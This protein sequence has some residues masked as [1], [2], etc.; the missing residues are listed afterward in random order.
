MKPFWALYRKEFQQYLYSLLSYIFIVVFLVT[1]SWLFWRNV[2]LVGQTN[3]RDFFV[4]M[5][6][7]YLFLMPAL[8]M[9]LWSEEKRS[10]TTEKLFTFPLSDTQAVLA[11]FTAAATFLA[12]VLGLSLP[13]PYT[14]SKIGSLDWGPVIGSYIGAWLLGSAYLALGQWISGLTK[15]Q[16]VAFLITIIAAFG[17]LIIGLPVIQGANSLIGT[18]FYTL[19]TQTHFTNL[20]KGVI[21]LRDVVYYVSFI[22]VF[23][24]LNIQTLLKRQQTIHRTAQ[25]VLV[26]AI[27][28]V[29]NILLSSAVWRVDLTASK[30]FT[31][32]QAS[33]NI[34]TQ[35]TDP[36]TIKVMFS[37]ELP[38]NLLALRQDVHDLVGEYKRMGKGN[39]T[40]EFVDPKSDT[41]VTTQAQT[42]GVPEIQFNVVGNESF[43]V[44]T[45]YAGIVMLYHDQ[46]Q[47]IP[48]IQDTANLEYDITS[49]LYKM[50]RPD[51]PSIGLLTGYGEV[52][53]GNLQ[54][55]LE[56]Q[57]TVESLTIDNLATTPVKTLMI[58]GPT[59]E[60][61]DKDF[62]AIDQFIMRG[63]NVFVAIDGSIINPQLLQPTPNIT[64]LNQLLS[65][66]GITVNADLIA[67]FGAAATLPFGSGGYQ[68][69]RE[70]PYWPQVSSSGFNPESPVTQ[71]LQGMIL[72]WPS[73]LTTATKDT[74]HVTELVRTTDQSQAIANAT[75]IDPE[76]L[77][78]P[79]PDALHSQ[80]VAAMSS[81]A[82]PSYYATKDK[83][84]DI[85]SSA[86]SA[87][88]TN[89]K[90]VVIS[91]AQFISDDMLQQTS[92]NALI[93]LNAVDVLS[94]DESLVSIRSR[95]AL[96]RPLNV[97]D[98]SRKAVIRYT[99]TFYSIILVLVFAGIMY[100]VRK[101]QASKAQ[102]LY[103]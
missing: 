8:S 64:N 26:V 1:L 6:W 13:I 41:T 97:V 12:I 42:Y 48:V 80:V 32:S 10:G 56:K 30:Q 75:S 17:F 21:D 86:F 15:N 3:M 47:T 29:G 84:A 69:L 98:D 58:I 43:N 31:L 89:S 92:D 82:L 87:Q 67:D 22:G 35:A 2:F 33:R 93:A 54:Q 20:S 65:N 27:A 95:S 68:V 70:Y 76:T 81:G 28:I 60:F 24:F 4:L 62:Y 55:M 53:L 90:V 83:P 51:A 88:S 34:V 77:P 19:S 37:Q 38:Q 101:R 103:V 39:V 78:A 66:Y 100:G 5:P 52:S 96:S 57:Y 71:N 50:S 46:H 61:A 11:K 44:S 23:L 79:T 73:S 25:I 59:K 94:Q 72:P 74:L 9:R 102:R 36:I 14:L 40:V 63:G 7:F 85:D 49:A 18:I 45:G 99:N 91:S 16:I